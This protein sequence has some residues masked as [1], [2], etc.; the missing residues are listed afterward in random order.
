MLLRSH[1]SSLNN[2]PTDL[3]L[4]GTKQNESPRAEDKCLDADTY[5]R[6]FEFVQNVNEWW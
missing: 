3:P 6:F 2:R 1:F 4:V 5:H